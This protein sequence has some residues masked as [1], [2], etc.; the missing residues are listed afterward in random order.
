M[1]KTYQVLGFGLF[2]SLNLA[3]LLNLAVFSKSQSSGILV[4]SDYPAPNYGF[5]VDAFD[6][7]EN[8]RYSLARE[9]YKDNVLIANID[10]RYV[11][12]DACFAYTMFFCSARFNEIMSPNELDSF[13][14]PNGF[15]QE[16]YYF[17]LWSPDGRQIAF[18]EVN[19]EAIFLGDPQIMNADGSDIVD[20]TPDESD[21]GFYFSWSPDSLQIAFACYAQE[22]LC[23]S[24]VDG[25]NLQQ[26]SVPENK[27]VRDVAWSPNSNQ[28]A[29]IL[30]DKEHQNA[31]LYILNSDGLALHHLLEAGEN[32]HESPLWSPDGSRIAFRSGEDGNNIGEI[33]VIDSDGT[34]LYNISHTLNGSEFGAVWSPD[35][36]SLAFFSR[37]TSRGTFLYI[38]DRDGS[39]LQE[40]TE[41]HTDSLT[42]VPAPSLF[43]LP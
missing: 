19:R 31:E 5:T 40:I 29:F 20:L 41:N 4:F 12:V 24:N 23:I 15:W 2:L 26:I 8:R 21:N 9:W 16:N 33:Y 1:N 10:E 11:Y 13:N 14:F 34:N 38:S 17:P 43:W 27:T 39:N 30:L 42:D 35:G 32:F 6:L 37:Q 7:D 28:I 3:I 36:N 22:Y 18:T 25:S